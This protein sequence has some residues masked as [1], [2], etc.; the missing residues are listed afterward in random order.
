MKA[1]AIVCALLVAPGN[2]L[3]ADTT[4]AAGASTGTQ[5]SAAQTPSFT[6]DQLNNM[7]APIALYPDELLSQIL[8]ASTYPLELVQVY[9]WV[10]QHPELKG[11]DLTTA[12]QKQAWDPSIQALV[13]FPDVLKRLNQDVTWTT[14]LGNAFLANQADVMDAV[15]RMRAQA[16]QAGKLA[17]TSQQTVEHKTEN[18][19][20]VIQIEPASPDIVYVPD[21][22]PVWI[23]GPSVYYRYPFWYYPPPPPFGIWCWW[24]APIAVGL[25]FAGWHGWAD[26]G[27]HPYWFHR[28]IVMNQSFV[29]MNHF[30][31]VHVRGSNGVSVW[32][33]SADHRMGVAYPNREL[34]N[35]FGSAGF[36]RPAHVSVPQARQQ[37]HQ[38]SLRAQA[39]P[40][41]FGSRQI[42]PGVYNHN[43]TA[44]GGIAE[45]GQATR[46]QSSRG[47]SSI[48]HVQSSG[49]SSRASSW[50]GSGGSG[51]FGGH[52]GWSG[53]GGRSR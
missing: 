21:Y 26:W 12:A 34:A 47:N 6:P 33:H 45:G 20:S 14:G 52:G 48:G 13:A 29:T 8:V 24:G 41:R 2:F 32:E 3:F 16:D 35:H 53:G 25:V 15:Q 40:D 49:A 9:Q 17:S 30:N 46:M 50:G 44:F 7:V 43:R 11:Q 51:G 42:S 18:G 4:Q 38:A 19:Q 39:S 31:T 28:N 1:L 27:W 5:A 22:D 23:W 10:Q 36:V 37:F